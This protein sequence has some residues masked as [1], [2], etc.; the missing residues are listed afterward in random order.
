MDIR[1]SLD[2][3]TQPLLAD[4][5]VETQGLRDLSFDLELVDYLHVHGQDLIHI[6]SKVCSRH[7]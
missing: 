2:D 1:R 7:N 3:G 5:E 4:Q 6:H